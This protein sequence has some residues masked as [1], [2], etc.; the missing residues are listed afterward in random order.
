MEAVG[1]QQFATCGAVGIDPG[2]TALGW[3]TPDGR[4]GLVESKLRGVARLDEIARQFV[5]ILDGI[6]NGCQ[7]SGIRCQVSDT[8][9]GL[10]APQVFVAI[11]GYSFGARNQAHQMGE[12]GGVLRLAMWRERIPFVDVPPTMVKKFA[13]DKGNL[14]KDE[15]RLAV[16]KRWQ[17][18]FKSEHEVDAFVL[19][20][21]AEAVTRDVGGLTKPQR[22]ITEKLKSQIVTFNH[23]STL[24]GGRNGDAGPLSDSGTRTAPRTRRSRTAL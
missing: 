8:A 18:E 21:I 17:R 13:G 14:K 12:L 10:V 20:K 22:E 24:V 11:E 1:S 3:A 4:S 6:T 5:Q 23:Q 15:M 7:G 16:F 2:L 19:A 9:N